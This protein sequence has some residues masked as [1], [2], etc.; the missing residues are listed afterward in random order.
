MSPLVPKEKIL[1]TPYNIPERLAAWNV[2]EGELLP[3]DI[4]CKREGTNQINIG[5]KDAILAQEKI[6]IENNF[7][8]ALSGRYQPGHDHMSPVIAKMLA[9]LG[10]PHF[11]IDIPKHLGTLTKP[12]NKDFCLWKLKPNH[13]EM[14]S[15]ATQLAK[16][17][18][19][20]HDRLKVKKD[21]AKL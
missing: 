11:I 13:D 18:A 17:I 5:D 8:V 20:D 15:I 12:G 3:I 7:Q 14:Y 9:D 16:S 10:V 19:A 21:A 4:V 1:V 2:Y 6:L